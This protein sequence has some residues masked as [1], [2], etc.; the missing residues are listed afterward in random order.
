VVDKPTPVLAPGATFDI[1]F[2]IPVGGYDPDCDFQ[3]I[4]D[5]NNEVSESSE[6]NNRGSG[7]CIG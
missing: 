4:V 2:P 1:A 5:V 7:V 3:I 6:G